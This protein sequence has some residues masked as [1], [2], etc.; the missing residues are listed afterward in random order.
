L[1]TAED[2]ATRW[3]RAMITLSTVTFMLLHI[4]RNLFTAPHAQI[5]VDFYG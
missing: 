1:E 2:M 4:C 5:F 3:A